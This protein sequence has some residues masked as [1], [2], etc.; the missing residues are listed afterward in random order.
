ML[1]I[2]DLNGR[3]IDLVEKFWEAN[4]KPI[5]LSKIGFE[6]A[7]ELGK[8]AKQIAGGLERYIRT[9]LSE[10]VQIIQHRAHPLVKSAIP[11]KVDIES[12]GGADKI[13]QRNADSTS[14][15]EARYVPAFWAAF[16]KPLDESKK[17]YLHLGYPVWFEDKEEESLKDNFVEIESNYIAEEES[18]PSDILNCI[19]KWLKD[20]DILG[21]QFLLDDRPS[22]L[23]KKRADSV[24]DRII[25]SLGHSDLTRIQM[26][27]DVIKILRDT[28][29]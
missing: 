20:S 1:E 25:D 15:G 29:K 10:D 6:D 3:I 22:N 17:R 4:N 23:K 18:D 16:K 7:G 13:L 26:P 11:M 9:Y 2:S 19:K 8:S 14:P 12:L 21:N 24:L 28:A 27:L 5:L